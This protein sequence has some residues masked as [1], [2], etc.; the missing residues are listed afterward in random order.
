MAVAR[1]PLADRTRE[2]VQFRQ[3]RLITSNGKENAP[4]SFLLG[5]EA[6]DPASRLCDILYRFAQRDLHAETAA[7]VN[8]YLGAPE[9]RFAPCY[10]GESPTQDEKCPV[11]SADCRPNAFKYSGS[12][13]IGSHIHACLLRAQQEKVQEYVETNYIPTTCPWHRCKVQQVF[14]TRPEFVEHFRKHR[15]SFGLLATRK[16]K[17]RS[18]QVMIGDELCLEE[19]ND[20]WDRHFAQVHSINILEKVEVHYCAKCPEWLV[21]ELG[22]GLAWDGHLWDHWE[23]DYG[24]FNER[25]TEEVDLT[26]DVEFSAAVDNLVSFAVGSGFSRTRPEF[27]GLV[28]HGV[29]EVPMHCPWCVYQAER[30]R[31]RMHEFLTVESFFRHIRQHLDEMS[32]EETQQCP[33]PHCGVHEFTGFELKTHMVAFHRIPLFGSKNTVKVRTLKLPPIPVPEPFPAATIEMDVDVPAPPTA[34]A[35]IADTN[36]TQHQAATKVYKEQRAAASAEAVWGHCYGCSCPYKNIGAHINTTKCRSKNQYQLIVE[37]KRTGVKKLAWDL[38]D[39][40]PELRT[41][42]S[43]WGLVSALPTG[44]LHFPWRP[45][46]PPSF[47]NRARQ[48]DR[49]VPSDWIARRDRHHPC[50][51]EPMSHRPLRRPRSRLS[52]CIAVTDAVRHS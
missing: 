11:C 15:D 39:V 47:R 2:S 8:A 40:V 52:Q 41:A 32:D 48:N 42:G 17:T 31:I 13:T 12:Q 14:Q 21:D 16:H 20:D 24:R 45:Q 51:S 22:D 1:P 49:A 50:Q 9:R 43:R 36:L 38:S 23:E 34:A 5:I 26:P 7:A 29:A 46:P 10:Q 37:G 18:C 3:P 28:R 4:T 27:H 30:I 44:S 19:D 25:V 6:L 33:V 35:P